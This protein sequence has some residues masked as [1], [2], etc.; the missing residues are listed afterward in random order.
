[1]SQGTKIRYLPALDGLRAFAVAG[2]ICYHGSLSW[3]GGGF[4]GVDA[5]FVLSGFLITTLLLREWRSSTHGTEWNAV[6]RIDLKGFWTRRARR[7]LP[8][9]LLVLAAVAIYAVLVAAPDELHTIRGDGIASLFYVANWRFIFNGQ[10]YFAQ[11]GA[12]SPL[13][14]FW[15]LAIEEQFYLL[16]PLIVYGILRWRNGSVRALATL[17]AVVAT[18]SAVLMFV[19][20]TPGQDPSR[21]YYG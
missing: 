16:W 2:V 18:A 21:V 5:F 20:Y 7:L 15:S 8:A 12:P 11:F 1:M 6:G 9:L 17:A 14:H 3:A 4:L 19:L 13:K 10:S